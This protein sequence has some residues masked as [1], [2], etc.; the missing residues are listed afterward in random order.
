[1]ERTKNFIKYDFFFLEKINELKI[2]FYFILI[3]SCF[4]ICVSFL[5]YFFII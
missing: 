1:M 5:F 3:I 2:N 4:L